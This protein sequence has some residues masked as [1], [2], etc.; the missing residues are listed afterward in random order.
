MS[1]DDNSDM[2]DPNSQEFWDDLTPV[3][4]GLNRRQQATR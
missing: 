4:T 3:T 1:Y 2:T